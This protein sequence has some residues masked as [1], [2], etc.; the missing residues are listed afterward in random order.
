MEES[1]PMWRVCPHCWAS[2]LLAIKR[3]TLHSELTLVH[4]L[5]ITVLQHSYPPSYPPQLFFN[6]LTMITVYFNLSSLLLI[7]VF[8]QY[9][10]W[11]LTWTSRE[12]QPAEIWPGRRSKVFIQYGKSC[13]TCLVTRPAEAAVSLR[14]AWS[15]PGAV[16]LTFSLTGEKVFFS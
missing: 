2:L 1:C 12:T 14:I 16:V 5:F 3:E 6:S 10:L 7:F 13:S 8:P 11:K 9:S 4:H 15:P